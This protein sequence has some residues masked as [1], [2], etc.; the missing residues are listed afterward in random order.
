MIRPPFTQKQLA[1][2]KARVYVNG[3]SLSQWCVETG[4]DYQ[5]AGNILRGHLKA[6]RGEAFRVAAALG[7]KPERQI[8]STWNGVDRRNQDRR[9]TDRAPATDSP[10]SQPSA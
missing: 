2:A 7:L 3:R 1:A 8:T 6:T 4:H 9:A 10:V 5:T